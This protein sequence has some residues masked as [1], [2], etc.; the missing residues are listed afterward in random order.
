MSFEIYNFFIES[1]LSSF[2]L[3]QT[4]VSQNTY[5][6]TI[7]RVRLAIHLL[8]SYHQNQISTERILDSCGFRNKIYL[9]Y[10]SITRKKWR[11]RYMPDTFW[12]SSSKLIELFQ[13]IEQNVTVD[14]LFTSL[15][16]AKKKKEKQTSLVGTPDA[17][18]EIKCVIWN[19]VLWKWRF[20]L[21]IYSLLVLK[22]QIF[23]MDSSVPMTKKYKETRNR[24]I[25][26][27]EKNVSLLTKCQAI[28]SHIKFKMLAIIKT[29]YYSNI[30]W[31]F[32]SWL[33]WKM[34][35]K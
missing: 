7:R 30:N 18:I 27:N 4:T 35:Q 12:E 3:D 22:H 13:N 5:F 17:K 14:T 19:K 33:H 8:S 9:E 34:Q 11:T 32:A 2:E 10:I 1:C 29:N 15:E 6:L 28:F 20:G 16:L 26:Y 21:K 31:L 23:S 24:H 25:F